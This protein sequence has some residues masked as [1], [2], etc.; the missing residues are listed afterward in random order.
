M[1]CYNAIGVKQPNQGEPVQFKWKGSQF[2]YDFEIGCG[3]CT[4]CRAK[5]ARDWAIRLYCE[6]RLHAQST[7]ITL[8]YSPDHMPEDGKLRVSD[9]QKFIKRL[10][11]HLKVPIRY[12]IAGEY[13][14]LYGRPHY[15]AII[16]GTDFLAVSRKNGN[17]TYNCPLLDDI[18][19]MGN[20]ISIPVQPASIRYVAGYTVKK[21]DAPDT[22]ALMSR[23]PPIGYEYAKQKATLMAQRGGHYTGMMT[24]GNAQ[25][26]IP[27][28]FMEWF[29][30]E[31]EH[32]IQ[33]RRDYVPEYRNGEINRNREIN[34]S[35]AHMK[36]TSRI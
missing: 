5:E 26:P 21:I 6:S 27:R 32:V 18:W 23:R 35:A 36:S 24:F 29:P 7:N 33:H 9:C 2:D 12:F 17:G 34:K 20:T 13:G 11:H 19:G 3:K 15:H 16:Y 28:V 30:D 4:G 10:R 14:D 8:T 22:F 31:F 25:V 1:P